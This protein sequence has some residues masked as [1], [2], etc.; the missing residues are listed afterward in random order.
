[1]QFAA[2][3]KTSTLLTETKSSSF[4]LRRRALGGREKETGSVAGAAAWNRLLG[5]ARAKLEKTFCDS[6][7]LQFP[8]E[9]FHSRRKLQNLSLNLLF[10]RQLLEV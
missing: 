9:L 6:S 5:T 3:P 1:V 7:S 2:A 8:L 4:A 10:E